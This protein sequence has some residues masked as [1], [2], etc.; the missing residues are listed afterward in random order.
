MNGSHDPNKLQDILDGF[1]QKYVLCPGCQNPETVLSV[2]RDQITTSC[3]ACGYSGLLTHKDKVSTFILKH[4]SVDSKKKKDDKNKKSRGKKGDDDS[5]EQP[6]G[7]DNGLLNH[8]D[9]DDR[10][11]DDEDW[12]DD[13]DADAVAKRMSMLSTGVNRLMANDD[14]EK[15]PEERLQIFFEHLKVSTSSK[16]AKTG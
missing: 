6:P 2:K 13:T 16:I 8:D 12:C 11:E 10:N 1:I 4:K 15:T 14:L 3:K 5:D 9:A 7:D